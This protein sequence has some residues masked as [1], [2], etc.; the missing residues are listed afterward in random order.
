MF[1]IPEKDKQFVVDNASMSRGNIYSTFNVMFDAD[2]GRIKLNPPLTITRSTTD[3]ADFVAPISI[4]VSSKN[5]GSG[6]DAYIL[7]EKSSGFGGVWSTTTFG[8]LT[9]ADAPAKARPSS[10]DMCLF[11]GALTV[12]DDDGLHYV[13]PDASAGAWTVNADAKFKNRFILIPFID[14][15]RLY[16]FSSSN[17]ASCDTAYT[18]VNSG[19]YSQTNLAN[20]T[21]ARASSKRI[22]YATQTEASGYGDCKIYEW[23]GV[24]VNPLNIYTINTRKIQAITILNDLPVAIDDKGRLWFFDGYTFKLKDGVNLP[25]REDDFGSQ[26]CYVHRNGMITLREKICVL[27]G[28]ASSTKNTTERALS[29]IWCYDPVIGF[30]HYSSPDNNTVITTPYALSKGL[31][32]NVYIAGYGISLPSANAVLSFTEQ[33]GG[34]SGS[35]RTGFITTQF[36]ES[37]NLTDMLNSIGIKYRKPFYSGFSVEVKYRTFKNVEC[38]STLT[39]TDY[40]TFTATKSSLDGTGTYCTPVAAGDE[41]MVQE[42]ANVGLIAHIISRTDGATN[43]TIVL[44]RSGT[45]NTGSSYAM[46]SNYT[47]LKTITNDGATFKNI[48]LGLPTT[49]LQVKL[50][51]QWK[52]YHDEIQ[53]IMIPEKQNETTT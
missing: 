47:L 49:M 39:W 21:C 14:T 42:G 31:S 30:Y 15:N 23:D 29:G 43:A 44:D 13:A 7:T 17:V 45:A 40:N 51:M 37:K 12:S 19:A 11:N 2:K 27:I 38:N 5:N 41:V 22:W 36:V 9:G 26:T 8:K 35:L 16:L 34:V 25:Y 33:S 3:N 32:D 24:L 1:R 52:G 6:G 50:V 10:S 4:V 48:R 20:I 53:E 46:F 18:V 28:S